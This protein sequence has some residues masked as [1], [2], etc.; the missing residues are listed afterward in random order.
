VVSDRLPALLRVGSRQ[1]L[2]VRVMSR[3]L[4]KTTGKE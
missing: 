1:A 3:R 2:E 4:Q